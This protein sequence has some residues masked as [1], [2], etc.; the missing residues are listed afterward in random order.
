M[1]LRSRRAGSAAART[2]GAPPPPREERR[3]PCTAVCLRGLPQAGRRG[4]QAG[5]GRWRRGRDCRAGELLR[6]A[7]GR[8]SCTQPQMRSLTGRARTYQPPARA[9]LAPARACPSRRR[10]PRRAQPRYPTSSRVVSWASASR[11]GPRCSPPACSHA[12]PAPAA[13]ALTPPPAAARSA[14]PPADLWVAAAGS[15]RGEGWRS[16]GRPDLAGE[17]APPAEW[18]RARAKAIDLPSG[19]ELGCSMGGG[20]G[21]GG[22]G[23]AGDG[24]G[25]EEERWVGGG[26][27][28]R[29]GRDGGGKEEE[30]GFGRRRKGGEPW[31]VHRTVQNFLADVDEWEAEKA[32][33]FNI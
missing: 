25:R 24:D 18:R 22:G 7:T 15:G 28:S 8:W 30:A 4:R 11:R 3:R 17:G 16:G 23:A 31:D 32:C 2:C 21:G 10:R 9:P 20:E 1:E 13:P 29:G 6:A 5:A 33:V 26:L 12:R 27:E 14:P 19:A